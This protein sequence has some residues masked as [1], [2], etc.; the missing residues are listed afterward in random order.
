MLDSS[1]RSFELNPQVCCEGGATR[2]EKV[3][4]LSGQKRKLDLSHHYL[5]FVGMGEQRI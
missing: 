5:R 1:N 2:R 3:T 4:L